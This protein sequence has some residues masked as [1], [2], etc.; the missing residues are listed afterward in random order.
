MGG[1]SRISCVKGSRRAKDSCVRRG[2]RIEF[3]TVFSSLYVLFFHWKLLFAL[4]L[5][6]VDF[7][8]RLV[9]G[10]LMCL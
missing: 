8:Y 10:V 6:L 1:G 9:C 2:G 5:A 3:E 7:F 4:L